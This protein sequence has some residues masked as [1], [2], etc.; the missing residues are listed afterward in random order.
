MQPSEFEQS[1]DPVVAVDRLEMTYRAPVRAA[2]LGAAFRALWRREHQRV[3]AVADI[4]FDLSAGEIV[5]LIGPNG[6]GKTTTMKIL[7][8]ILHPTSGR[9][10]VLGFEPMRR[11]NAFLKQIA[12]VRGSQ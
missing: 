4:S 7:S 1:T 6:A 3:T 5:G 12:L 11:Q 9:S 10:L 8:G 2:G